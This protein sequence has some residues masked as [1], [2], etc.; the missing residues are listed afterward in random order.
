MTSCQCKKR[1]S[2]SQRNWTE[3]VSTDCRPANTTSRRWMKWDVAPKRPAGASR[4]VSDG[5]IASPGRLFTS[6]GGIRRQPCGRCGS[7]PAMPSLG[8]QTR[9][10]WQCRSPC[11]SGRDISTAAFHRVMPQCFAWIAG[12]FCDTPLSGCH[13]PTSLYLSCWKVLIM[14]WPKSY[15]GKTIKKKC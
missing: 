4:G 11:R 12:V 13:L 5:H 15:H 9:A 3:G 7:N 1:Q 14:M 6:D 2:F 10:P 8:T